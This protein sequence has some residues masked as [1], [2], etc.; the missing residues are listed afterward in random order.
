MTHATELHTDY[1]GLRLRSPLVA[2]AGPYTGDLDK[3]VELQEA[4]AGAI[5]L[6]SLFEEQIEHETAEIDRLFSVHHESFG[7][8]SS[9]FP[10]V[11]DYNTGTDAYL[12]LIE[13]AKNRVAIPVMASL[14]G[15]NVGGW[16]RY[17]RLLEDAGADAIELNLYTVA[18]DPA[19]SGAAIEAEQ[20]ELV[21]LLADEVGIPVAVKISPHYSSLASFLHGLQ[22]AGAAGLVLFNRFYLP[23][24]DLETLDIKPKVS[25]SSPAEL[26]LPLRWIGIAREF[27]SISIAGSTG[28]HSGRDAAKLILAG[29]NVTMTTS[30]L[31]FHGAGY[32]ATIEAE[33]RQW[34]SDH[35]YRSVDEMCGAV[36]RDAAADPTA[37]ERANYIGNLTSYTSRFLGAQG[38]GLRG[39]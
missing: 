30:A 11:D 4:G 13:A 7:E 22:E 39:T 21:A 28:V 1:L 34:M 8:A 32:L 19:I 35:E 37:Y 17:A 24:L 16:L 5:V 33:L 36:S 14:N 12:G 27:L 18:A 23:D 26:R 15:T 3:M 10:E 2:S 31:L 25:L 9:F 20:L 6:P 38:I 29:A